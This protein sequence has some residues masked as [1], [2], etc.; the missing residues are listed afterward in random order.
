MHAFLALIFRTV[1]QR[2]P[3]FR[4]DVDIEVIEVVV[5]TINGSRFP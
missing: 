2:R 4:T 3:L 1:S 5:H